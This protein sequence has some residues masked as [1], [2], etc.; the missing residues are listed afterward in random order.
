MPNLA[1][2]YQRM[3]GP[4]YD[5]LIPVAILLSSGHAGI[6]DTPAQAVAGRPVRHTN[7]ILP[8]VAVTRDEGSRQSPSPRR[9]P[10]RPRSSKVVVVPARSSESS[11]PTFGEKSS[12]DWPDTVS[13]R[14]A[15]SDGAKGVHPSRADLM[16]IRGQ[17]HA[18]RALEVAA[19]GAHNMLE[20][21]TPSPNAV[22]NGLAD[23]IG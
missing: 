12:Y 13:G 17:E 3:V 16:D 4:A 19:S 15:S 10:E 14:D 7:G 18:K 11:S 23:R 22:G 1:L 8:M 9:T 20:K 6:G 5:L 2:V 21:W